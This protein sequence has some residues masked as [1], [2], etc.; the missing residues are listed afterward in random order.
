MSAR[1]ANEALVRL[2]IAEYDH[3]PESAKDT[4]KLLATLLRKDALPKAGRDFIAEQLEELARGGTVIPK[5]RKKHKTYTNIGLWAEVAREVE[6]SKPGH[7]DMGEIYKRVGARH[8]LK[9][10]STIKEVSKGRGY[11]QRFY[12]ENIATATPDEVISALA[13]HLGVPVA[14]LQKLLFTPPIG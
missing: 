8:D 1:E 13:K 10:A 11:L 7:G 3:S 4:L 2:L 9:A 14:T 12:D 5:R 6:K